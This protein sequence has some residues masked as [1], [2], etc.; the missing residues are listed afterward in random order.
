MG[1]KALNTVNSCII[2][3]AKSTACPPPLPLL[4]LWRPPN[5]SHMCVTP[6]G[7]PQ[8]A[9]NTQGP[10]GSLIT[11]SPLF[12]FLMWTFYLAFLKLRSL[13]RGRGQD[14]VSDWISSV[15]S[16]SVERREILNM[17]H[18]FPSSVMKEFELHV[19]LNSFNSSL[20]Q[21]LRSSSRLWINHMQWDVWYEKG[22]QR[23]M[24][25]WYYVGCGFWFCRAP[26]FDHM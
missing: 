14:V 24:W 10:G 8:N 25:L 13:P 16:R 20:L 7:L 19:D 9:Q 26:G 23:T 21:L 2:L 15:Q 4:F 18:W 5:Q 6:P 11:A 12:L 17:W 3:Y 1:W 22:T